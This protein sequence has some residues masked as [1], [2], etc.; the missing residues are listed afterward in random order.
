VPTGA[1]GAD[2]LRSTRLAP[3]LQLQ[4][5]APAGGQRRRPLV[6]RRGWHGA[7]VRAVRGRGPAMAAAGVP[8]PGGPG[9]SPAATPSRPANGCSQPECQRG[10]GQPGWQAPGPDRALARFLLPGPAQSECPLNL[11]V[12]PGVR[13]VH[14]VQPRHGAPTVFLLAMRSTRGA[15][16]S[17]WQLQF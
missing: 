3:G 8:R 10:R 1:S 6:R 4:W 5:P 13:R 15:R 2:S 17:C 11:N 14:A 9:D 12:T 16:S 7:V